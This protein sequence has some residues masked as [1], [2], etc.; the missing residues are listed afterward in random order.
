MAN[1]WQDKRTFVDE[2]KFVSAKVHQGHPRVH[3][4]KKKQAFGELKNVMHNQIGATP[5]KGVFKEINPLAGGTANKKSCIQYEAQKTKHAL[6]PSELFDLFDFP[7]SCCT[8]SCTKSVEEIWAENDGL[9]EAALLKAMEKIRNGGP[10]LDYDENQDGYVEK[11][12]EPEDD[13]NVLLTKSVNPYLYLE[14]YDNGDFSS[15]SAELPKFDF[16]N[17]ILLSC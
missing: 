4:V 5:L 10:I 11:F 14:D 1:I 9:D 3:S 2:N 15:C 8:N 16:G 6:D 7:K 12:E 17:D 13:L